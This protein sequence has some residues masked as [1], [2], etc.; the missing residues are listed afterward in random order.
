MN[1]EKALPKIVN[2]KRIDTVLNRKVACLPL[3]SKVVCVIN[4]AGQRFEIGQIWH[5]G[6]YGIDVK[7][8]S[9]QKPVERSEGEF[10][11]VLKP[12]LSNQAVANFDI[13]TALNFLSY[14]R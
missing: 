12:L 13:E 10:R 2:Q 14:A 8:T 1:E 9:I 5:L 7:L 6:E 4:T 11:V 3:R